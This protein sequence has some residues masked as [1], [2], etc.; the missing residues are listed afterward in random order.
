MNNYTSQELILIQ[1]MAL[2]KASAAQIAEKLPR[3]SRNSIIG[4]CRRKTIK[5]QYV[6]ERRSRK[7]SKGFEHN[8]SHTTLTFASKRLPSVIK[9]ATASIL[10]LDHCR[11]L[12]GEP[13]EF[14]WCKNKPH[15]NRSYCI[16]HCRQVYQGFRE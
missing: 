16:H 14:R 13:R 8:G 9:K 11:W 2:E 4:F 12:S 1:K 6:S 7:A 3:H 5:L 10:K 15:N